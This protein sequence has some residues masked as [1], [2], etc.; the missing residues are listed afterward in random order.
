[1]IGRFWPIKQPWRCPNCENVGTYKRV[2]TDQDKCIVITPEGKYSNVCV[3][4]S[5]IEHNYELYISGL[6]DN[7]YSPFK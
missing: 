5:T 2:P 3:S 7:T 6:I 1:M 4:T